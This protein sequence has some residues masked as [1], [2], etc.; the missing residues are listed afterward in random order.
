MKSNSGNTLFKNILKLISGESIGR[1]IGFMAAPFITRLYTPSDFGILAVFASLCA[2]FYPFCTLKYTVAIPLHPN[3]KIGINSLAA[4]LYLLVINTVI[5]SITLLFSHSQILSLFSSENIDAFWYFIPLTFFF[6]GISE[7]LSYYSTRYRDFS[8]I[9]KVTVVQKAIGALTKIVFGLFRF[10]VIGLLI[11]DI[12]AE[13]G[14]LTL[15]IRIYWK[16]LKEGAR[17]VTPGK[18]R[19]ILK[20]YIDFPLYRLPSQILQNASGSILMLYFAWHFGTDTTGRISLAMTMLSAPVS[21]A[22]TSVG[23]AFYGEIA[24]LGRKNS[25]EISALTVRIMV[26]L[27]AISIVPFILIICFGPWIFRTFFGAEWTQSGIFA[28][29]LCFYLIFRFV[30][31]PISDGI[32]NVFEQQKLLFWL[33]VSRVM[34][35]ASG[36]I[37]SCFRNF[38][39]TNTIVIYSLALMVQYILSIILVF[40]IL[41]KRYE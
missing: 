12:M 26:R 9:A 2:L 16:R 14:G 35:V 15:Y 8:T 22:C 3:E 6:Y 25:K 40:Y 5:I 30:Y 21:F 19:F 23:K 10:N 27:F 4:C 33:E 36:L 41:K 39:V 31:S 34:I 38:S 18:I 1:V 37:I 20:R 32:F 7:I 29:Y 17:H 24:S 11:G 13:S 28:R